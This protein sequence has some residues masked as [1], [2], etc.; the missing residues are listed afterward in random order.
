LRGVLLA[1]IKEVDSGAS[2]VMVLFLAHSD[3]ICGCHIGI[4]YVFGAS[5]HCMLS[6]HRSITYGGHIK[7]SHM[8]A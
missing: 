7:A 5:G 3:I 4:L 1:H 6:A 2:Y 8:A